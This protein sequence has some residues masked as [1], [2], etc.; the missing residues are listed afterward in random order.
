VAAY[1]SV[2]EQL[3]GK[4]K[5]KTVIITLRED[6][7]VLKNSWAAI[8]LTGGKF[9]ESPKHIVEIVDRV[10]GGDSLSGA[11][12]AATMNGKDPDYALKFA[13]AFSALQH[14]FPGDY[15]WATPAEAE[16]LMA[17]GETRIVR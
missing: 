13:V 17:G 6:L 10:G 14:S 8:C 11:Y 4:F 3:A 7:S 12:I 2:A 15:S 1:K 9:F 16:K 5:F